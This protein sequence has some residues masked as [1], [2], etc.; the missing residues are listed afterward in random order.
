MHP[1]RALVQLHMRQRAD[2]FRVAEVEGGDPAG[3]AAVG[4]AAWLPAAVPAG[5]TGCGARGDIATG[6]G[7]SKAC[8]VTGPKRRW[9]L[10]C[11]ELGKP[12]HVGVRVRSRGV[13]AGGRD[14]CGDLILS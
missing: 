8:L 2:V 9:R 6:T 1:G 3:P 7:Q 4:R 12:G 13:G 5:H 14:V 11:K 10:M